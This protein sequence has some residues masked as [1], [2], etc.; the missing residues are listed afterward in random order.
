[1][2]Q[3]P[4][5]GRQ[6]ASPGQNKNGAQADMNTDGIPT[7]ERQARSSQIPH[8]QPETANRPATAD[9]AAAGTPAR[10]K[11]TKS[12]DM[13]DQVDAHTAKLLLARRIRSAR[14][15]TDQTPEEQAEM[16]NDINEFNRLGA[17]MPETAAPQ[18]DN[19]AMLHGVHVLVTSDEENEDGPAGHG[20]DPPPR[21]RRYRW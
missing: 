10:S 2:N 9:A 6:S 12:D 8:S 17:E 18:V 20:H 1:M 14:K 3:L 13:G 7:D 19:I 21:K 4:N 5:G 16:E 11:I 15:N